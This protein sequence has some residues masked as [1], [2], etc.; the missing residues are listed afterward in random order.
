MGEMFD[1]EVIEF[2]RALA[3]NNNR[4]WFEAN[5]DFYKRAKAKFEEG[6]A[7]FI[8]LVQEVDP[9]VGPMEVKNCTYRIYKDVRFSK[10]KS[11]Y[12]INMGAFVVKDGKK[13]GNAGYYIHI[14]PDACFFGGGLH[15]PEPEALLKTRIAI[16]HSGDNFEAILEKPSFKKTFG[17]ID[18]ES[19]K[20]APKGFPKD[21]K[22]VDLLKYKS[23][24]VGRA[25]TDDEAFKT[26][27]SEKL[28]VEIAEMKPFIGFLNDGLK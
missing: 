28:K 24:T 8:A 12:K 23:Y 25:L 5:N 3:V 15:C 7:R 21:F 17:G 19:L 6:A 4:E 14:E 27:F 9:T 16:L 13:S 26:N 1:K 10:D 18:C 11:P 22:Q 2:L 20:T